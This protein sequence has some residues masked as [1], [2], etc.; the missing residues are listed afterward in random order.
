MVRHQHTDTAS[1]EKRKGY[2]PFQGSPNKMDYALSRVD[3]LI[4][5]ARKVYCIILFSR[6]QALIHSL[7]LRSISVFFL[8]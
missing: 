1:I 2:S 4:N 6:C 7:S 5:W 3:D 8:F